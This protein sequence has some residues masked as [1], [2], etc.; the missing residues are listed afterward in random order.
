MQEVNLITVG[1]CRGDF[2]GLLASKLSP[3]R[4]SKV[5]VRRG[6]GLPWRPV[7][8][9]TG[10]VLAAGEDNKRGSGFLVLHRGVVD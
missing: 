4:I 1:F 6:P 8:G 5:S 2:D 10:S 3:R 9:G 7:A